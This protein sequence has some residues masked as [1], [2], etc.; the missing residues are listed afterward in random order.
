MQLSI[1][2]APYK[3]YALLRLEHFSTLAENPHTGHRYVTVFRDF[4]QVGE[5]VWFPTNSLWYTYNYS[6]ERQQSW[7][8]TEQATF[9]RLQANQPLDENLFFYRFPLGTLVSTQEGMEPEPDVFSPKQMVKTTPFELE[10]LA[11]DDQ[12][13][14]PLTGKEFQDLKK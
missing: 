6:P 13:R 14:Q 11:E 1:W 8:S 2:V 3:G 4:Q 12:L 5:N 9:T 10:R 7:S